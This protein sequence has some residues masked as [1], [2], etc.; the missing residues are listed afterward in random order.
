MSNTK[1]DIR[2]KVIKLT[3][4]TLGREEQEINDNSKFIDDLGAD[5]LDVVE[6]MMALEAEFDCTISDEEAKKIVTV[7]DAVEA[8]IAHTKDKE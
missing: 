4:E 1:E 7:Q 5:S 6:F 2:Q 8:I 3:A